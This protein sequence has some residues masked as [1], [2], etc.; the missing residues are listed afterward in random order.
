MSGIVQGLI[1][2]FK[3]A[4][5]ATSDAY[6]NLVALLLKTGS[7]TGAQNNTFLDSANRAVFVGSI[8]GTTLTVTSVT[9]G[10]I[11]IGTGISG[12][13]VTAGTTITAGSGTSWTVSASQTVA[14]TTITATGI[15]VTR[16]GSTG[17]GTFTPFSQ[18][19]WAIYCP[20][21]VV[22]TQTTLTAAVTAFGT[23][24]LTI[25][26]NYYLIA[27][28]SGSNGYIYDGGTN[29]IGILI[30]S[31][32]Q[33]RVFQRDGAG[34]LTDLI[35]ASSATAIAFNTWTHIAVVRTGTGAGQLTL[36]ING[37]PVATGT[38][39]TNYTS[40]T[41]YINGR[42]VGTS[43]NY[44]PNQ[45]YISN[46]RVSTISR[47]IAV[48]TAFYTS[49]ANTTLLTFISNRFIN[50]VN[51]NALTIT[52][53]PSIQAFS[54]FN[55]TVEYSPAVV[56]G[57]GYFDGSGDYLSLPALTRLNLSGGGAFTIEMM[58]YPIAAGTMHIYND[59]LS[60]GYWDAWITS[61]GTITV[62]W[63]NA[64]NTF[65][66]VLKVI[67]GSWNHI[68]IVWTGSAWRVYINGAQDAT[69]S[70]TSIASHANATTVIGYSNYGPVP[71][72]LNGYL[73]NYRIVKGVAVYT[74]AFTPPTAYLSTSGAASASAYP[75]TTNVN[76]TFAASSC[77]LLLNA[78]NAGIY[79]AA[80]KNDFQTVGNAQVVTPPVPKFSTAVY[81][82]GAGDYL[83]FPVRGADFG[84]GDFTIELWFYKLSTG[85]QRLV[86][87]RA[88]ND[89]LTIGVNSSN[90]LNAFYGDTTV[91]GT[92]VGTTTI[93]IN[94]WYYVTLVRSNGTTTLY[95]DG[96]VEG[97]P[98][99]WA[100]K[101]FVST[102]Y[103]IGSSLDTRNEHFN[104]YMEEVRFTKY[105]RPATVP[106]AP[107]F[108]L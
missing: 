40:T 76:T 42:Y 6:F 91:A 26:L 104:G 96:S 30:D 68:A 31:T 36:Y 1:A 98:T 87:A 60:G 32:D 20:T 55:P 107:F 73:T 41:A 14:S 100:A 5:A 53:T 8:S 19:G 62:R 33:L 108:P 78:T 80:S 89:G 22:A 7:T 12:T 90:V 99:S 2:S 13:G 106:T 86:S 11:V 44:Y 66:T 49:D 24:N 18:T 103:R 37:V 27:R 101:S 88:N 48:P 43:G 63:N 51:G 56:G 94:T 70:S 64:G 17:Q 54:P 81:F 71:N 39:A 65:T 15:P 82:D 67:F 38:S 79:D 58:C 85:G 57:S 72:Y 69:T 25:E 84:S 74:G 45:C 10:T 105:A 9:S 3:S 46:L 77:S 93:A 97:T 4:A 83:D 50:V 16:N 92:I 59:T 52:G 95:L 34:A 47:T 75:S 102:A 21:N 35:P 61:S 28:A 23:G 29:G